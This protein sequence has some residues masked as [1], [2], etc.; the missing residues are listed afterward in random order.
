[1]RVRN[2][3]IA[4]SIA[5]T[6]DMMKRVFSKPRLVWNAELKLSPPPKALPTDA[7]VCCKSIAV[8]IRTANMI[9]IYGNMVEIVIT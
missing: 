8:I 1:M 9:W 2:A 5:S 7:L 4:K 3:E 6:I